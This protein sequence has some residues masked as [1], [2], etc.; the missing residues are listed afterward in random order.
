M[1]CDKIY[2]QL[3]LKPG[4]P[5][6]MSAA[7]PSVLSL[8]SKFV[9]GKHKKEIGEFKL[10]FILNQMSGKIYIN[11]LSVFPQLLVKLLAYSVIVKGTS[12]F[13]SNTL[14]I[15]FSIMLQFIWFTE[16]IK[17]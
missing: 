5:V 17:L 14:L 15:R 2:W 13:T 6:P 4:Y 12:G 7:L 9:H 16:C 10:R 8:Q 11:H 3:D 1:G